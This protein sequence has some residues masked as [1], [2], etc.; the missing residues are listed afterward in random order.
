MN[1][2]KNYKVNNL[3]TSCTSNNIKINCLLC[4]SPICESC[5]CSEKYCSSCFQKPY[6]KSKIVKEIKKR[7]NSSFFFSCLSKKVYPL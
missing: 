3:C 6:N 1:N 2:Y 7:S 5:L 4:K